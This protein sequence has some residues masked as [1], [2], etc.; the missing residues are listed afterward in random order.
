MRKLLFDTEREE[1]RMAAQ[2]HLRHQRLY[3]GMAQP[4]EGE[5]G[6]AGPPPMAMPPMP[7]QGMAFPPFPFPPPPPGFKLP[8]MPGPNPEHY[9]QMFEG[10]M[11][12]GG[13]PGFPGFP[14]FPGMPFPMV[15]PGTPVAVPVADEEIKVKSEL[16]DPSAPVNEAI[17]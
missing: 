10:F 6:A 17:V 4:A 1:A 12:S 14:G 3:M 16:D 5:V 11:Q 15:P 2:E 9:R 7:P 8:P 13:S